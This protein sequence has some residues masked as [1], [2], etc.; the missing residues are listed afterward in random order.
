[1]IFHSE[2]Y[3]KVIKNFEE[4]SYMAK[5][6]GKNEK[7]QVGNVQHR[8]PTVREPT[9]VAHFVILCTNFIEKNKK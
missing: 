6:L 2:L 9:I 1:M 4:L 3:T 5:N 7:M 8:L